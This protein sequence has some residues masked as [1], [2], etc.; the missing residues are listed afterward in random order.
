VGI[1]FRQFIEL[2]PGVV[3]VV[4]LWIGLS[5]GAVFGLVVASIACHFGLRIK[6]DTESLATE[7]TNSVVTAITLVIV[8]DAIFAIIFQGVGL[9]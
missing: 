4:N 3:P 9:P 1:N 5:K 2:L 6:P 7:T 8:V